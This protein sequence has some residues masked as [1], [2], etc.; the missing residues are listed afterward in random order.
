MLYAAEEIHGLTQ[1]LGS[2]ARISG[3]SAVDGPSHGLLGLTEPIRRLARAFTHR[4]VG[5]AVPLRIAA[6]R[7]LGARC[8]ATLSPGA[9]Q[10]LQLPLQLLR[11]PPQH[12]LLPALLG[13]LLRLVTMLG[14]QLAL[15]AGELVE[16]L[17][18]VIHDPEC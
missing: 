5:V 6:P 17:Q 9:R 4:T 13:S 3:R 8:L 18:S 12:L 2:P 16:F 10:L 11:L 7:A 14:G 15:P 1:L